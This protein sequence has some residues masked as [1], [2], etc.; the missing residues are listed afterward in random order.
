MPIRRLVGIAAGLLLAPALARAQ[1]VV[2]LSGRVLGEN[3][4]PIP[5]ASVIAQGINLGAQSNTEGRYSF[6]IPRER[7][8]SGRVTLVARAINYKPA[9]VQVDVSGGEVTQDFALAANPLQLGEIVVTGAGTVQEVEKIGN[10]RNYVDSTLIQ[11][12]NEE[13]IVNALA[14]KA[15]NVNV[16]STAGD[17]GA[18]SSIQIRGINTLNGS[19]QPLII[20]DGMPIDNTT[21]TTSTYDGTGFGNQQGTF[22]P[23]RAID[24]NP[25]DIENVEV[26]KGAAAGSVYGARAGQGV[27]LITT[28]KGRPGTTSY[29]LHSSISTSSVTRFPELQRKFGQGEGGVA[30]VCV[31]SS[32]PALIDCS[33]TTRSWGPPIPAGTPTFDHSD[34]VFTT[35]YTTDNTLSISGGNDRTT[36]YLSGSEYFQRGTFVGPNNR[37]ERTAFRLKGDHRISDKVQVGGNVAYSSDNTKSLQ[38]TSNFSGILLG[39]WRSTPTFDNREY[40][41]PVNHLQRSFAYPN[42]SASSFDQPRG[43]DNPF[44]T[45]YVPV[46][47]S[48]ANRVTGNI[49]L[50]AQPLSW[51]NLS[52]TLG[53]DYSDDDRLQGQPQTSSN[54]PLATGQVIS[55][56]ISNTQ[57]ESSLLGTA[58]YTLSP[59]VQGTFSLGQDFNNRSFRLT[60]GVGNGLIASQPYSL[61]NTGSQGP[62]VDSTAKVNID[63]YFGQATVDLDQQLYLKAG[64]RYDGA[65]TFG[66]NNLRNWFPS[67]SAAW[68]FTKVLGNLDSNLTYGK[69]RI[70]YGEV[71]TQPPPYLGATVFTGG[72]TITDPFGPFLNEN[73]KGIGGLVTPLIRPSPDLKVERSKELELGADLGLFR[74]YA[75]LSFTW[76][77]KISDDV[78]LP[79]PVPAS[80]GYQ[81]QYT[82][83]AKIRNSGTEWAL[84]IRPVTK[85]DFAWDLGFILGT[86]RNRVLDIKGADF[87]SYGGLGGFALSVADKGGEV[88]DFLDFDYVRCGRGITLDNGSGGVY[89]VDA[90]CTSGQRSQHALFIPDG[91]LASVNGGLGAGYPLLDPTK[92]IIGSPNPKW[93]GSVRTSIRWK[94][95]SLS[96]LLDI[97]H[98][99]LIYNGTKGALVELGT[100]KITERRGQTDNMGHFLGQPVAGPGAGTNVVLTED[101]FRGYYSTF[102][103]L[104]EPFYEDGS[105]AKLREISIGYLWDSPFVTR[106]L[107]LS[108]IEIRVA[109][110]NLHTW[111]KYSG[112]DPET[113]FAGA[114]SGAAGI[115]WFNNPQARS[116]VFSLT[117]NR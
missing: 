111:T 109:G 75:D 49:D 3:G 97:R 72:G 54:T 24:M 92:R 15:P 94:K 106:T 17:P 2:R 64:L 107:G 11:R 89:N 43:Y 71:G 7:L 79:V 32:D 101:F 36:F 61:K 96:G 70:A 69:L 23:N 10:V 95:F 59:K 113:S 48:N 74:D 52:Y 16:T 78:I 98:G 53:V 47:N 56:G 86:N 51:L 84:N 114:E 4:A 99:G 30:E 46:G 91:T 19:S 103:S 115:D 41:D 110:R 57:V 31:P 73:Q 27:I 25:A 28:K 93:T 9:T 82:N 62:P 34:E 58:S 85:R 83:A 112:I 44:F 63:G 38:K 20:V 26:L 5:G 100:A 108:S 37:F 104:G 90:N 81:L 60:G 35:G 77:H 8:P 42:P 65:S 80:T 117:V 45:A 12:S 87:I 6:A 88:G 40:L 55:L 116:F 18:S 29:S 21:I 102:V 22:A 66:S 76:Y 68:Q 105:Y 67:A 50:K 14:A 33:G 13:N 39:S 1:E